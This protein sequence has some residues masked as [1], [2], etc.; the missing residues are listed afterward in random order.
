MLIFVFFLV[1]M[2]GQQISF[3]PLSSVRQ[4]NTRLAIRV[5]VSRLWHHR[6]GSD[7]GHIFFFEMGAKALPHIY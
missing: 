5:Y 7:T 3:D 1:Q 4:G 6:S 2:A